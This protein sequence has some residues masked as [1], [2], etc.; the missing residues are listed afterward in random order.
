ML[1]LIDTRARL[2]SFMKLLIFCGVF[3]AAS[4]V[5]NYFRGA[6]G[7]NKAGE[8]VRI[9]GYGT[10]FSNPNELA[11]T[12]NLIMPFAVVFGLTSKGVKRLAFFAVA[13]LLAFAVVVAF[14]RGGFL[15][16]VAIGGVLIWKAGRGRRFM[17]VCAGVVIAT[18]F[19]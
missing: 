3:V 8:L 1:N 16:L 14:P 12:V 2:R 18:A 4:A 7:G 11:M 15:G 10:F 19:V 9:A 5:L 6:T 13:A 17:A